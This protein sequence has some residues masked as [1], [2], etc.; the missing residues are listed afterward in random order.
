MKINTFFK[1]HEQY[2]KVCLI[3]SFFREDACRFTLF[4]ITSIDIWLSLVFNTSI[5]NDNVCLV[6]DSYNEKGTYFKHLDNLKIL[7]LRSK[8]YIS[9]LC[10][11]ILYCK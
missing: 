8:S 4:S 5:S 2:C 1:S 7:C 3:R 9:I 11:D 10:L 6:K